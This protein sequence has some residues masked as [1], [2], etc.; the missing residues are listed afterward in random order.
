MISGARCRVLPREPPGLGTY[1]RTSP[2]GRVHRR[3]TEAGGLRAEARFST[4]ARTGLEPALLRAPAYPRRGRRPCS[5]NRPALDR[6]SHR[7]RPAFSFLGQSLQAERREGGGEGRL[8]RSHRLGAAAPALL[9][10][11]FHRSLARRLLLPHGPPGAG[12]A[13][14]ASPPALPDR[15]GIGPDGAAARRSKFSALRV[16]SWEW[17]I[18]DYSRQ[19]S[20]FHAKLRRL[21]RPLRA[22]RQFA[23]TASKPPRRFAPRGSFPPLSSGI[24]VPADLLVP[25]WAPSNGAVAPGQ[26]ANPKSVIRCMNTSRRFSL[27]II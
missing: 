12:R 2:G 5:S 25:P 15:E 14:R 4:P 18:P 24:P 7:R 8:G 23:P 11:H 27:F 21:R 22:P 10:P 13:R 19:A 16:G 6:A 20:A 9:P 17:G 1:P 3:L 26:A